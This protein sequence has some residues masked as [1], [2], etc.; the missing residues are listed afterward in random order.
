[1][2]T[3]C[4]GA[5]WFLTAVLSGFGSVMMAVPYFMISAVIHRAIPA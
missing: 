5:S 2:R 1:V 4:V 3:S